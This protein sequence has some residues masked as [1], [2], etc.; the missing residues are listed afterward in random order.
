[1]N[2]NRMAFVVFYQGKRVLERIKNL[3]VDVAYIS[4]KQNYAILY[5]DMEQAE[6]LRKKLRM[7]KGFKFIGPSHMY[8]ENL[9]F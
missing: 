2:V 4:K 5:G 6:N 3:P 8:D 7:V 9:N 1:M